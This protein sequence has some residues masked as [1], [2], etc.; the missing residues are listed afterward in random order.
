MR[1]QQQCAGR[2][3]LSLAHCT[4]Q[5]GFQQ[6]RQSA[7][8]LK[9]SLVLLFA[10][11]CGLSVANVYCA[12]PLLDAIARDFG[13]SQASAGLVVTVTQAGYALGLFFIVPL[14]D[15]LDRRRLVVSQ[16]LISVLALIAVG[17]SPN[18]AVMLCSVFV[19]GMLAVV[20]Q[21]LVAF[22]ATLATPEERGNV[23]G[24]VT[25]GVVIGILIARAA[26]GVL[27]DIGGWRSVYLVSASLLL[28]LAAALWK[29][30][31]PGGNPDAPPSYRQLLISVF[32][33][34]G[35]EPVLRVRAGLAL[36]IF[37]VFNVLWTPLVLPLS[38]PPISL[39]HT[40]IGL[41]GLVGAAG[42]FAAARAGRFADRGL[43][44][45]TTGAALVLLL[46]SWPAIGFLHRS[47]VALV[48]GIV[49]LDLAVQAVHVT[50]QS[51]IFARSPEARSRVV[52]VYMT[53]YS[54]GSGAGAIASTWVFA[55][56]GWGG[57]SL[58]G[59]GLSA[60]ALAFWASTRQ[61]TRGDS[62]VHLSSTTLEGEPYDSLPHNRY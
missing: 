35:H 25:S 47:L 5:Q 59:A 38:S 37:A 13:V 60:T 36:L 41:F 52:A 54:V 31:P 44:Q 10:V 33:L 26:A 32:S 45:W 27:T 62:K 51:L 4:E 6:N 30:L 17:I 55:H 14:G 21:V 22:A 49:M 24:R 16:L 48:A 46:A 18:M 9:R 19:V 39:S 61:V 43:A 28:L 8:V 57:V 29:A 11:A 15:L 58:L 34:W 12:Q 53:F 56:A 50:N 40:A 3:D 23:V 1:Q 20:I 7:F 2:Q 42:S